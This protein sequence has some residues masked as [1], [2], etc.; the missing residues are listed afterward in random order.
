MSRTLMILPLPRYVLDIP[1][2]RNPDLF[3]TFTRDE[4]RA[5][6]TVEGHL[7]KYV[8]LRSPNRRALAYPQF[9]GMLI[10]P[11][12]PTT[13]LGTLS[14]TPRP[15][16]PMITRKRKISPDLKLPLPG[17]HRSLLVTK[18]RMALSTPKT[19]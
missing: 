18:M 5:F 9:S 7:S 6:P 12:S 3:P 10:I 4:N 1:F 8:K 19:R 16:L 2:N 11:T 13:T 17:N 15:N 14:G